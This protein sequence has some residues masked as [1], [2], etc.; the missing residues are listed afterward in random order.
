MNFFIAA[1]LTVCLWATMAQAAPPKDPPSK[2]APDA[3]LVGSACIDK[4]EASVWLVPPT[5]AGGGSNKGLIKKIRKG[6]ATAADLTAGN[7]TQLGCPFAPYN[8]TAYP[9]GFPSDGNWAPDPVQPVPPSPGVYAVSIPGVLPTTCTT[10]FQAEQACALS[11]KRLLTNQE[12]QRAAASTPDPGI[13]DD[14]TTTCATN[15]PVTPPNTGARSSCVSA[16]GANDMIGSVWEWVGD[17]AD[18][19]GLCVDWTTEA[20]IAGGDISCFGG[21]GASSFRRIP[22]ALLRGGDRFYGESAGVFAVLA[23]FR[24]VTIQGSIGLRCAR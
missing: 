18:N 15:S 8:H 12:W 19:A 21:D 10:W 13:S 23:S 1:T 6:T 7:A 5:D 2:C 14:G 17:W 22:A 11:G 4:Y 9:V 24:P 16:W 3:V 20:G